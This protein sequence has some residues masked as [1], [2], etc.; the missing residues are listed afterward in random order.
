[1]CKYMGWS[2][3]ELH[4]VPIEVYEELMAMIQESQD[5]D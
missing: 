1:M 2:L 4:A 5:A 3:E